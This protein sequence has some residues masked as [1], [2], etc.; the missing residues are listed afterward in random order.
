MPPTKMSG[1]WH[2]AGLCS[3]LKY[4]TS[5]HLRCLS[6]EGTADRRAPI[7][8]WADSWYSMAGAATTTRYFTI[9][10]AIRLLSNAYDKEGAQVRL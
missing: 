10:N 9:T 6:C 1:T 4:T 5:A 3:D 7:L 2:M 8:F